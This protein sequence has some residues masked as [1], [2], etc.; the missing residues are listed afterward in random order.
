MKKLIYKLFS[1]ILMFTLLFS[2]VNATIENTQTYI[3][4]SDTED[5]LNI[6]D[7]RDWNEETEFV[8]TDLEPGVKYHLRV[9]S[10]NGDGVETKNDE[11]YDATTIMA[12]I[13]SDSLVNER[14]ADVGD[15]VTLIFK[16]DE[17]LI[18]DDLKVK[19]AGIEVAKE[20]IEKIEDNK[21]KAKIKLS[22]EYEVYNGKIPFVISFNFKYNDEEYEEYKVIET[23]DN[24]FVFF[25]D[26]NSSS[27][28]SSIDEAKNLL[29]L[30]KELK[31]IIDKILVDELVESIIDSVIALNDL[32]ISDII[33]VIE[34]IGEFINEE[35]IS[36]EKGHKLIEKLLEKAIE[37]A[38]DNEDL[39]DIKE[40][41]DN[42]TLPEDV[43]NRLKEE[44][45]DRE[46]LNNVVIDD[47]QAPPVIILDSLTSGR[48]YRIVITDKETNGVIRTINTLG[49]VSKEVPEFVEGRT[50][51]IKIDIVK[52]ENEEIIASRIFEI[53]IKDL[54][55]PD[56]TGIYILN[57]QLTVLA[58]DNVDLHNKA[59]AFRIIQ[60]G[61]NVEEIESSI[62]DNDY[63]SRIYTLSGDGMTTI[64]YQNE[65]NTEIRPVKKVIV[66]VRDE[67]GNISLIT[68]DVTKANENLY[69]EIPQN[70][71]D[72]IN[73]NNNPPKPDKESKDRDK[74]PV[75]TI[76]VNKELEGEL[77]EAI[78]GTLKNDNLTV[79]VKNTEPNSQRGE[80]SIN[81]K[82]DIK[83]LN[84]LVEQQLGSGGS[85]L[86]YRINVIEKETNRLVY[87]KLLSSAENIVIPDL[88]DSTL[89]LIQI[90]IVKD[91][92]ELAF[93]TIEKMTYDRTPPTIEQVLVKGSTLEVLAYDNFKL[94]DKA[95]Q[96]LVDNVIRLA[97]NEK[98]EVFLVAA[99]E[100][101]PSL[102]WSSELWTEENKLR[103]LDTDAKVRVI[104][105]DASNNYSVADVVVKDGT[106]YNT[107]N[108]DNPMAIQKDEQIPVDKLIE[109]IID[110]YNAKNP[111][112]QIKYTGNPKDYDVTTNDPNIAAIEGNRFIT[113]Q[114]GLVTI[115]ITDKVNDKSYSYSIL[116]TKYTMFDRR[117]IVQAKSQTELLKA[118]EKPLYKEF[119]GRTV[120][121]YLENKN[122]GKL[123]E[124][125]FVAGED[126]G[127]VTLIA[128]DGQR[129][130]PLYIVIA[131]DNYP[132][133]DVEL[134]ISNI[135]YVLKIGD[136]INIKDVSIFY[137]KEINK[138]KTEYLVTE[139][140]GETLKL[141]KTNIE[142]VNEGK[143]TINV[144]DLANNRIEIIELIVIDFVEAIF[145]NNANHWA[146]EEYD[147]LAAKGILT[148]K[149][150]EIDLN[151]YVTIK[152]FLEMLSRTK[153]YCRNNPATGRVVMPFEM[154]KDETY[155]YVMDALINM[156]IFEIEAILGDEFRLEDDITRE[157]VAAILA[158]TLKFEATDNVPFTDIEEANFKAQ[159]IATFD[160]NLMIGIGNKQFAKDSKLSYGELIKLAYNLSK[161][162]D[163]VLNK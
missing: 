40:V 22:E 98:M 47:T 149:Y 43:K 100:S 97:K 73:R 105:R 38:K 152:D 15:S 57:S 126:E 79:S 41:I 75:D 111:E 80:I 84:A 52:I 44:I 118:F 88:Q 134:I 56:I 68:V 117:I 36:E 127:I 125:I 20:R 46:S 71:K 13:K 158:L 69:G 7:T 8:I 19:I 99:D 25:Y 93:R 107:I 156:N 113:K 135:A 51:I 74:N 146:K 138:T 63:N 83:E 104:V 65:N 153:A 122:L 147:Y 101:L 26:E 77:K 6:I 120:A 34:I 82:K 114:S 18:S 21:Y 90:F 16:V 11:K 4:I 132:Q 64:N 62:K 49:G 143:G 86:H 94:H 139:L 35:I 72:Q 160:A 115:T 144:I 24:S 37:L 148:E 9:K 136:K 161:Y 109:K 141:N 39:E 32:T 10:K 102:D 128:T 42:S 145:K 155:Y 124:S 28:I 92:Q 60:E 54:T 23:T 33:E 130:M 108:S 29:E 162:K 87:T 5:F 112:E 119:L 17:N 142:A 129:Q 70:I 78:E 3:E 14:Y 154:E 67:A 140:D 110:E 12:T 150:E 159:I 95:Y 31:E 55:P 89:Y 66:I 53:T 2:T 131:K 45:F 151:K 81:V 96:Y 157:E 58:K 121:F 133:S 50:Y 137:D 103:K 48:E 106:T 61:E 30:I 91:G 163:E 76:T 27:N 59:Y 85:G 1:F 123:D 116:V